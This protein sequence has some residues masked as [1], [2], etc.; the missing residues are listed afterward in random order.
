MTGHQ[1]QYQEQDS[2][3]KPK[4]IIHDMIVSKHYDV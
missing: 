1:R 3:N 2:N 4:D